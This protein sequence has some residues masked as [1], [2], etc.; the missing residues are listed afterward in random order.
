MRRK[1]LNLLKPPGNAPRQLAGG[2]PYQVEWET[3][4]WQGINKALKAEIQP[5]PEGTEKGP[6]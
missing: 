5:L 6:Q 1:L 4:D 3:A 2:A